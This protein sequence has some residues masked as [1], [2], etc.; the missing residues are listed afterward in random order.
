MLDTILFDLDGTLLPIDEQVFTKAYFKALCAVLA[1]DG[2]EPQAFT[3]M[4]WAGT[5][6]MIKNDGSRPN[7]DVF[8]DEFKRLAPDC[9][10]ESVRA[11]C[12][13]F[14]ENEFDALKSVVGAA[15]YAAKIVHALRDKGYKVALATNPVFPLVAVKTRLKWI[16]LSA[17]DFDYVTTY[18]NS[19]FCK[20]SA[21]YY[22]DILN[23][24]GAR[25]SDCLMIGNHAVEDMCFAGM[26]GDV[27]LVTDHVINEA[28]M[29]ISKFRQSDMAG[30][31]AYVE[32]LPEV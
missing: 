9:D 23:A 20:P 13:A 7:I 15:P 25:I 30:L 12:D 18:E 31:M 5:K 27:Y 26:G 29:D 2:F 10:V 22:N 24:L 28:G 17:R 1:P 11:K 19:R 14:Y 4:I 16:G 21:G 6:C 32:T 8:W 3:Q